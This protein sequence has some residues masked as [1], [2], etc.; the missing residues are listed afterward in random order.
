MVLL[1][2]SSNNCIYTF[3]SWA[4]VFG[5]CKFTADFETWASPDD[6]A[7]MVHK[8]AQVG[9]GMSGR[10]SNGSL[11]QLETEMSQTTAHVHEQPTK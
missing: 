11:L 2:F 1:Q 5:C 8:W 10:P 4:C 3:T 6:I 7:D 9:A